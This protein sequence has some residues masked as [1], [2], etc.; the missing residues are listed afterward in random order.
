MSLIRQIDNY[1]FENQLGEVFHPPTS[2]VLGDKNVFE[3]DVLFISV[4][5]KSQIG[6]NRITGAPEF[7]VEILSKSTEGN[8]R[9]QKMTKYGEY[10]VIEYWIVHPKEEFIEV[11]HNENKE[12]QLVQTAKVGDSISSKAIEGFVL[13]LG[14]V[15]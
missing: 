12:M 11:Y 14:K 9:N 15:F 6:E 7:V 3:P 1:V 8:D 4:V 13:D 5:R 10:N 2:I